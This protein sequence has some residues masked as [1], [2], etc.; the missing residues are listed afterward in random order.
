MSTYE[1]RAAQTQDAVLDGQCDVIETHYETIKEAKARAKYLLTD[2]Y[3]KASESEAGPL[4]Y[5][6]VLKDGECVA[7][8][9][10]KATKGVPVYTHERF[11]KDVMSDFD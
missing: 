3:A 6:Q 1:V 2:E 4:A 8:Y 10:R 7:D 11:A 5:A 9:F